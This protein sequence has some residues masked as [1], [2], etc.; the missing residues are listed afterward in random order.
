MLYGFVVNSDKAREAR[1]LIFYIFISILKLQSRLL[2]FVQ[3]R[4]DLMIRL[5]SQ[6]LNVHDFSKRRT[7]SLTV[8][9]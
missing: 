1:A 8:S 5:P 9:K 2:H 7:S 3:D 6:R 4:M